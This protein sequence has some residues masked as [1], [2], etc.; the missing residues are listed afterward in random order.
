MFHPDNKTFHWLKTS[1]IRCCQYVNIVSIRSS[2]P[3]GYPLA[4]L[5]R[6]IPCLLEKTLHFL[7]SCGCSRNAPRFSVRWKSID[8]KLAC[9]FR[10]LRRTR[11]LHLVLQFAVIQLIEKYRRS[12]WPEK[13]RR[14]T[15]CSCDPDGCC[16]TN[17]FHIICFLGYSAIHGT[18]DI[19][20][21]GNFYRPDSN[22]STGYEKG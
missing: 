17:S 21:P 19:L 6:G 12:S 15:A 18:V 3:S 4:L 11:E 13:T 5:L 14:C 22:V 7:C 20:S 10:H 9:N 2:Q 16:F 1:E 8:Y